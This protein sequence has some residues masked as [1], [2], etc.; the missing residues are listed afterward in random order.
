MFGSFPGM[1]SG[2]P[3]AGPPRSPGVKLYEVLG[4][5]KDAP[6]SLIKKKYHKLALRYHPDKG[7]DRKKFEEITQAYE[8]L[9]DGEKRKMYDEHGEAALKFAETGQSPGV[10][11]DI[12][13]MFF[14]GR[15][16]G[17]PMRRQVSDTVV[18]VEVSLKELYCGIIKTVK[19]IRQRIHVAEGADKRNLTEVCQKCKGSG[20]IVYRR[21]FAGG[22][23]QQQGICEICQGAGKC[24]R[25]GSC[26]MLKEN[27][28]FRVKV[29]A[30]AVD[31]QEIR[32]AGQGNEHPGM[33]P[34]DLV[35]VLRQKGQEQ[36]QRRGDDLVTELGISF[37]QA[38]LGFRI[39]I[40]HLSG[41]KLIIE[42]KEITAPD[43]MKRIVG[44][45][46]PRTG[47]CGGY[48]DMI[49]VFRV[50]FPKTI[51]EKERLALESGYPPCPYEGPGKEV[52]LHPI[53][54]VPG[55]LQP[56][57]PGQPGV[58]CAQQ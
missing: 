22:M 14:G 38:L 50:T 8:I 40:T 6:A 13:N 18:G 33:E 5:A 4:V 32:S 24:I 57:H 16:Q 58:Q 35:V 31:H 51:T 1:F 29:P 30:G 56:D 53:R 36:Y 7:G 26:R 12:Y 10:P 34:G 39:A 28:S 23:M 43:S 52:Y 37:D 49:V 48:G 54:D 2:G 9:S 20:R 27:K 15:S 45:G 25:P 3:P 11:S 44:R 41:E 55:N 42:C 21:N 46:M 17:A 47:D 19:V